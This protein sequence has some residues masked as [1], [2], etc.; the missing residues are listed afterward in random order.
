MGGL[1]VHLLRAAAVVPDCR[2]R[3]CRHRGA[4][5]LACRIASSICDAEGKA[6][7]SVADITGE[8]D[9]EKGALDPDLTNLLLIAIGEVQNAGKKKR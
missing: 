4:D 7:F 1:Q 2:G 5:P 3:H 9:P 8:A 6:V